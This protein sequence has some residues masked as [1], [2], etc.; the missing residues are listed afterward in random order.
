MPT[1]NIFHQQRPEILEINWEK[2]CAELDFLSL[3]ILEM[4]Y[5]PASTAYTLQEIIKQL[6]RLQARPST[7]RN[8]IYEFDKLGLVRIM[9]NTRPLCVHSL[10]MH[11]SNVKKMV[12]LTYARFGIKS[13]N[14][15]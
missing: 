14:Q 3:K 12:L 5:C 11:E 7:I 8:R 10:P 13:V 4:F 1:P 6:K 2:L 15:E 9:P